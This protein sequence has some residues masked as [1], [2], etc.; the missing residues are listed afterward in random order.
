LI[1]RR[2]AAAVA[3][4]VLLGATVACGPSDPKDT[5][6]APSRPSTTA[7]GPSL[8]DQW[9]GFLAWLNVMLE[10]R[11]DE[12]APPKIGNE[13]GERPGELGEPIPP[14]ADTMPTT[15]TDTPPA[16]VG[17]AAPPAPAPTFDIPR[18]PVGGPN[19]ARP[20]STPAPPTTT[21]TENGR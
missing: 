15:S 10:R 11:P 8:V 16:P 14:A 4:A 21:T 12:P 6:V 19:P 5:R 20:S 18:P 9:T 3:A 1:I 13:P 17:T 7:A 2:V